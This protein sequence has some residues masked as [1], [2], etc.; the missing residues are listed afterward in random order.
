MTGAGSPAAVP[1]D[2]YEAIPQLRGG[3]LLFA[4]FEGSVS[5]DISVTRP[6]KG[7]PGTCFRFVMPTEAVRLMAQAGFDVVNIG[8]KHAGEAGPR[9][10]SRAIHAVQSNSRGCGTSV[11]DRL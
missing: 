8:K 3:D 1:V 6:C 7:R 9:A 2:L 4:N 11:G 5:D 10:V